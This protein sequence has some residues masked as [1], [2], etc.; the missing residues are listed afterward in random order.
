MI[1]LITLIGLTF[2]WH[3]ASAQSNESSS[4]KILVYPRPEGHFDRRHD[5][6]LQ[7]L[8]LAISKAQ[9][10]Y[11]LIP[12][13]IAMPQGRAFQ[14]LEKNRG[15]DIV[16]SMTS[17]EREEK[18]LPI[19]VPIMKGLIGWRIPL[20]LKA[21]Q[22]LFTK[23]TTLNQLRKFSVGQ[24]HDW[25]DTEILKHA[26]FDVQS[27][28]TYKG[29]F[30]MLINRRFDMFPRSVLEIW[31][32]EERYKKEG[33][34]AEQNIIIKYPTATYYF[35]N[36]D[37]TQLQEV[38]ASGLSIALEDGSFD[39]LF[40]RYYQSLINKANLNNRKVLVI[41]N[42]LLSAETPLKIQRLWYQPVH[43]DAE[44]HPM[45]VSYLSI[46]KLR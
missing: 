20:I 2:C 4:K 11:V 43:Y 29:L 25:P 23:S 7:L 46:T 15:I 41:N 30:E 8:E 44:T 5:Y 42:P 14:Q 33:V 19:R 18:F 9:H 21:N 38:I 16:W 40:Y 27:A 35:V 45:R 24:G 28:S 10:A 6:T 36:K 26:G 31:S 37:N 12:S 32:E 13:R 22:H 39:Q 34:M 1:F 3:S 17:I